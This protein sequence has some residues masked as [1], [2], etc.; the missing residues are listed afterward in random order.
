MKKIGIKITVLM[1]CIILIGVVATAGVSTII[2]GRALVDQTLTKVNNET[3]RQAMI[4]D[5]WLSIHKATVRAA[6]V[7]MAEIDIYSRDLVFEILKSGLSLESVY[8]DFYIGYP[9]N[10]AIMGSGFAIEEL[11]DWWRATERSWYKLALT[12]PN[13]AHVTS[14]YVDASTGELCI[15]VVHAI[16]RGREVVGVIAVDILITF[17]QEKTRESTPDVH[18]FA[19]L[20]DKNG[21]ILVHPD[22]A[23]APNAE[24]D[25]NNLGEVFNR[26]Y[27]DLWKQV[28]NT[29]GVYRY[30]DSGGNSNYYSSSTLNSTGWRLITVIPEQVVMQPIRNVIFLIVPIAIVVM[31][32]AFIAIYLTIR[33]TVTSPVG[34]LT[35]FMKKASSTGDFTM[36]PEDVANVGKYTQIGDEIG[37]CIGACAEFVGRVTAVSEALKKVADNDLTYELTPLSDKDVLGISLQKMTENL[38][39]M[40]ANIN[41]FATQVSTG[42]KQVA[43]G[44]Q[45][46]AQGST[47]Q[48]AAVQQLSSSV[49]E[50]AKKTKENAGMADRAATLANAIMSNAAKGSGQMDDMMSAVRDINQASHNISKV[51]KVI[52]DIAF[53]TNILALNAA[54]EAARAGQHGKGFAVVAEEVRNLAGKSAEAAKETGILIQNSMDKAELGSRIASETAA[55]LEEIVSGITE[56]T[57][58]VVEIA[59]SSEA[60]S[61]DIGQIDT[62]I[63][64]VGQVIQ[65]NSATAQESAA[66]SQQMS[67]QSALLEELVSQFK[68]K[69]STGNR[70]L[71]SASGAAPARHGIPGRTGN[72]NTGGGRDFGK[73]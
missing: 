26:A 69:D 55:S 34:L 1:L 62:G 72:T 7:A 40:F 10:T 38:D 33:K 36:Q 20:L 12:D 31:L 47:Q 61:L 45:S 6:A 23:L 70:R 54:V 41:A 66:V 46:L 67:G 2:S 16:T 49:S 30:T 32:G 3:G 51:I 65:Q 8:Q 17:L 15:T 13:T 19:M 39:R 35:G 57:K 60:Q 58:I 43:D 48:A 50:I 29:D 56:S 59:R 71:P 64:Q 9:D 24:G 11:Y 52:D 44:A 25:I 4:M 63:D 53:Q 73:Y 37:Q 68:L 5:E 22:A 42:S 28:S 18:G 21:D 27:A 14:P